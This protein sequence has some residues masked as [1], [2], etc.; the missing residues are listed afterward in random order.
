MLSV[1]PSDA[2]DPLVLALDVGSTGTRG[3][4]YDALGRPV[5]GQRHKVRHQFT[6]GADGTSTIDPDQ[7]VEEIVQ[8]I[9]EVLSKQHRGRIAGVGID[10]FSASLIGV[11]AD[12]RAVTPC[13][14]YADSRCAPQVAEL[15]NE[16]DELEVQQR[17]G[18]RIHSSY[19]PARLRWLAVT[20]PEL[21]AS[22]RTWLSLSE[23]VHLQLLG[24]TGAGTSVAAWTG[25]L[26]RHTADWD[27]EMLAA[28][29]ISAE[30]LSPVHHPDQPL[31]DTG[32]GHRVGGRGSGKNSGRPKHWDVVADVP[33]LPG[34][35]DGLASNV[36]AGGTDAHSWV[37]AAATS[38]AMRVLVDEVPER[39]G[40]GLWCY[41]V[42]RTRSL[43]GGA[44][45]DVG[46]AVAWLEG[47]AQLPPK[48][49]I[50]RAVLAGPSDNTPLILPFLTG[51]RST[52]WAGDARAVI[53]GLTAAHTGLDL[54]KGLLEGIALSYVRVAQQLA[55]IAGTPSQLLASG[56]VG[57]DLPEL[58]PVLADA[59]NAPVT[60]VTIKRSTLHG[61]ALLT[62]DLVLPYGTR[63]PADVA[64]THQ[65]RPECLPYYR[66]RQAEFERVYAGVLADD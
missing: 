6:T 31:T 53:T 28:A 10:T 18:T 41:R 48:E 21:V 23:Y 45:N 66:E 55:E 52:G 54:A 33:W 22:V 35:S 63:T 24:V 1:D 65:P 7:V 34:L 40:T 49:E 20:R 36:G 3:G 50:T 26:D 5:S 56:R 51:E 2:V 4:V 57:S 15:R 39:V 42:D 17:T 47:I 61:T 60:P 58:L 62:L 16:L 29:G 32:T 12:G 11:D 46:R 25:M 13:Y 19:L 44:L 43:V 14:T 37:L 59:M 27:P 64:E 30:Q 9:D 8:V 38:G